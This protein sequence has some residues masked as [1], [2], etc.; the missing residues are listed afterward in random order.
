[1]LLHLRTRITTL[2]TGKKKNKKNVFEVYV[3]FDMSIVLDWKAPAGTVQ[4]WVKYLPRFTKFADQF[5]YTEWEQLFEFTTD[6]LEKS[7]KIPGPAAA[8]L[9]KIILKL[10]PAPPTGLWPDLTW[11]DLTW[12]GLTWPDL[13]W[14]DLTWPGLTWPDLTWP[15]LTWP[16][17][18]WPDLTWPDLT[19]PD[20][21]WPDLTW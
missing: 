1:M 3:F 12:P 14:P 11:P 5:E 7:L 18:T 15:D 6:D 20:L 8:P 2:F 21:T 16:D 19:W 10:K 17:L 9:H 4:E 13:T